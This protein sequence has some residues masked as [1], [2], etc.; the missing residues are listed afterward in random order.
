MVS[1]IIQGPLNQISLG[2][3]PIYQ[4]FG[5]V[6]ISC[7]DS[8]NLRLIK[9]L[10]NVKI[11][12]NKFQETILHNNPQNLYRQVTTTL[13][14]IKEASND[15]CIKV[16]SDE[17]FSD[18]RPIIWSVEDNPN[19]ITCSNIYFRKCFRLHMS[20][21]IIGTNKELFTKA[22][23][24]T[25][26]MLET[27]SSAL[28]NTFPEIILTTVFL[29]CKGFRCRNPWESTHSPNS[30]EEI[31]LLK[32]NFIVI[33]V[34]LLGNFL[35]K[36][37]YVPPIKTRPPVKEEREDIEKIKSKIRH[38]YIDKED[39]ELMGIGGACIF[40]DIGEIDPRYKQI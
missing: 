26:H 4:D 6:I 7:W 14:G 28:G 32:N 13:A 1:I 24:K 23:E 9:N 40:K 36:C 22:L 21:H 35:I 20:D 27:G 17:Y 33:P 39:F 38:I 3:I 34:K 12:I 15:L 10:K 16:R 31:E 11:I 2:N 30:K 25:K 18:L 8:D 37:I 19:K 5:E 29:E